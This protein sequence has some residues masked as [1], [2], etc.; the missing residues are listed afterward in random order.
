[1][2]RVI[3]SLVSLCL[4]LSLGGCNSFQSVALTTD[5][6]P[7]SGD[8]LRQE[9]HDKIKDNK[10]LGYGNL[11]QYFPK[12]DV[13]PGTQNT[14]WGIYSYEEDGTLPY[15][16]TYG[17]DQCGSYKEEGDCFNREHS[18]PQS[19]W[20]GGDPPMKSD[21]FHIYPTD[22]EVNGLR[23]N[24]PYGE[25]RTGAASTVTENGSKLGQ[26]A[27]NCYRGT[28]FEPIDEFKGDL[29]RGYF[30]LL[31]RYMPQISS[32]NSPVLEGNNF[33]PCFKVLLLKWSKEDP[34]SEKEK[35]RNEAIKKLQG[36]YNP[37]I[38]DPTLIERIWGT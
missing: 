37:F 20:G 2:L 12:T 9:L 18:F 6:S 22:G 5:A 15:R 29:A 7:P 31:T 35:Q 11:W 24:H 27:M 33:S 28:V 1:M 36:N 17:E 16:F 19:W 25:V 4:F 21:L 14:V 32:W 10:V 3:N 26:S 23:A 13:L 38:E 8:V 30:Y 34:V